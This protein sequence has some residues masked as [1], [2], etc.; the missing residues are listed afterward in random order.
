[1]SRLALLG[2]AHTDRINEDSVCRVIRAIR[3]AGC[4]ERVPRHLVHLRVP[5][6]DFILVN[7]PYQV[8]FGVEKI[9]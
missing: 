7:Y 9:G 1:M 2:T 8:G 3:R 4:V 5:I 6:L